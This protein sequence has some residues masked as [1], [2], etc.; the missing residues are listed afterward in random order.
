MLLQIKSSFLHLK[1]LSNHMIPPSK[2]QK[3]GD[4]SL[5]TLGSKTNTGT[6]TELINIRN[7]ASA[8]TATN[9]PHK[10]NIEIYGSAYVS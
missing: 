5:K 10:G 1:V 3:S 7:D 9:I 4:D 8:I 6:K 2:A